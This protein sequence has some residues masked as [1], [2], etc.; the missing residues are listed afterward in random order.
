ME[1]VEKELWKEW[2]E[3]WRTSKPP[4]NLSL[5]DDD[6]K[7]FEKIT[8]ELV[9]RHIAD[10][11]KITQ[12]WLESFQASSSANAARSGILHKAIMDILNVVESGVPPVTEDVHD[13]AISA[14]MQY[15]RVKG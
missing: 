12:H 2:E 14:L 13:I 11:T 4:F 5:T 1:N 8:K 3:Y 6:R 10:R 15:K 9:E 7:H